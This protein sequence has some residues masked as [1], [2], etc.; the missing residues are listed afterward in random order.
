MTK[1]WA[2]GIPKSLETRQKMSEAARGRKP[3]LAARLG[4]SKSNRERGCSQ[5]TQCLFLRAFGE[6][7]IR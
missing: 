5:E 4:A 6:R 7:N 3:S 2:N 1:G